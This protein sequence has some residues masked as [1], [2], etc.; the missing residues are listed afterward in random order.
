MPASG[1]RGAEPAARLPSEPPDHDPLS[2]PRKRALE[3]PER[4]RH[5]GRRGRPSCATVL[6]SRCWAAS[7]SPASCAFKSRCE[8]IED[9]SAVRAATAR[10]IAVARRERAL[11]AASVHPATRASSA[12]RSVA[13]ASQ[14][15]LVLLDPLTIQPIQRRR[16]PIH[17]ARATEGCPGRAAGASSPRVRVCRGA[18]VGAPTSGRSVSAVFCSAAARALAVATCS[19]VRRRSR[20][21]PASS[22]DLS[23]AIDFELAQSRRAAVRS[24][25]ASESDSRCSAR[26]RSAA[27]FDAASTRGLI[28]RRRLRARVADTARDHDERARRASSLEKRFPI[29]IAWNRHAEI[30][31]DGWRDVHDRRADRIPRATPAGSRSAPRRSSRSR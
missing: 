31:Q 16:G 13:S 7:S 9:T 14:R 19:R 2:R 26:I 18:P 1:N 12:W 5:G 25:D 28:R 24:C 20:S 17:A 22:S 3:R 27:R 29:D 4:Q 11:V 15:P 8:S 6:W 30:L 10:S 23:S 21:A